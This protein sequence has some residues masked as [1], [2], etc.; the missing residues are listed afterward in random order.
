MLA[1][2][3]AWAANYA[4]CVLDKLPGVANDVAAQAVHQVCLS[5]HPGGLEGVQQGAGRGFLAPKSGADCTAKRAADTR[6]NQAAYLIGV[7]CRRLYDDAPPGL[8]PF[9]GK[10]DGE[11]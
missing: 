8:K 2:A 10:L 6:S 3:P 7:A 1:S 11:N 4:S 5:E 9:S